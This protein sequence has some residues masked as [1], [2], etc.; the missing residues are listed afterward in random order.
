MPQMKIKKVL[1]E[2]SGTGNLPEKSSFVA[3]GE[4][5]ELTRI[6]P[7]SVA[8]LLELG[9][10][11]PV[12]T[13]AREYLFNMRDVYRIRKLLRL[14]NDLGLS[15]LGGS[16]IVDLLERIEELEQRIAEMERLV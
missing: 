12:Q 9:W 1:C 5:V 8:E 6:D 2:V 3:W 15:A 13:G 10:L 11:S 14:R 16:I 7:S 4:F